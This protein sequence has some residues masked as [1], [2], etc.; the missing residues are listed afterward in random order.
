M[1]IFNGAQW[2]L[3]LNHLPVVIPLIG[4]AMLGLGFVFRSRHL[5]R[6]GG[7]LITVAALSA[8]PVFL[9]GEPAEAVVKNYPGASRLLI[10]DHQAAALW[11]LIGLEVAGGVSVIAILAETF[12]KSPRIRRVGWG[13]AIFASVMALGWVSWTAHLGGLIAHE[14]IRTSDRF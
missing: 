4:A 12:H 3:L 13:A 14:E 8:I 9:T 10:H 6:T 5:L 11:A 1:P 2:H 7:S